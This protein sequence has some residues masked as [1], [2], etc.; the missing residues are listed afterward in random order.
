MKK[1]N[2][3]IFYSFIV[4]LFSCEKI[5]LSEPKIKPNI[6]FNTLDDLG[7]V[8]FKSQ[9][10]QI[11]SLKWD[12]GDGTF[13]REK[14]TTK[15]YADNGKWTVK[16]T[17]FKA[18]WKYYDSL[19]VE[20]KNYPKDTLN[21]KGLFLR[22]Y[23]YGIFLNNKL[24]RILDY[25]GTIGLKESD[26][27]F[28][29]AK[30][31]GGNYDKVEIQMQNFESEN[32]KALSEKTDIYGKVFFEAKNKPFIVVVSNLNPRGFKASDL[33]VDNN[34][35]PSDK[36]YKTV[37]I[38]SY[39]LNVHFNGS[40]LKQYGGSVGSFQEAL[41]NSPL[42]LKKVDELNKLDLRKFE[43]ISPMEPFYYFRGF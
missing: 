7:A 4:L 6:S 30:G 10:E 13:S 2:I 5:G 16:Y 15:I 22:S 23:T 38:T 39:T 41:N 9:T 19:K 40:D 29:A 20:I 18:K 11:D 31:I 17:A 35:M 28:N 21:L 26:R 37:K 8:E 3:P 43:G 25:F 36:I 14:S 42:T 12:F 1:I 32:L 34:G 27:M 24:D 33:G